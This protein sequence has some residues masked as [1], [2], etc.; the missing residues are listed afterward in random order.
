MPKI[1]AGVPLLLSAL[2]MRH[3]RKKIV[4]TVAVGAASVIVAKALLEK[5][6]E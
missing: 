6:K 1:K 2:N 5:P 3:K 4:R